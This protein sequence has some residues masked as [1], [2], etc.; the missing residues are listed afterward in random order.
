MRIRKRSDNKAN[1]TIIEYENRQ[2]IR[3]SRYR[4]L[5]KIIENERSAVI[6]VDTNHGIGR[7]PLDTI[8]D[9]FKKTDIEYTVMPVKPNKSM[10]FGL[11][12]DFTPKKNEEKLLVF[13][14]CGDQFTELLYKTCLECYDV[15]IGIGRTKPVKEICDCLSAQGEVLFNELF[16]R[17]SVYDSVVCSLMR[18]STDV[19]K[20]VEAVENEVAL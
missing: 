2:D 13:Q 17:D 7:K 20:Y 10:F 5:K 14:L 12:V 4:L 3:V 11:N 6:I 18:S 1:E 9:F 8:E 16:F 19:Q 15:A